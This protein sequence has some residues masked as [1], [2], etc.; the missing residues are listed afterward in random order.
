MR[1]AGLFDTLS[2]CYIYASAY[3]I[4]CQVGDLLH[5][6]LNFA[7]LVLRIINSKFLNSKT[8]LLSEV[9]SQGTPE[10]LV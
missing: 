1:Q 8:C 3:S 4:H 7:L 5:Y 9:L 10:S 2:V 6:Q